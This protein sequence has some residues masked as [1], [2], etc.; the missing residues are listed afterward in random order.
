MGQRSWVRGQEFL[1]LCRGPELGSITH[2]GQLLMPVTPAP[3]DPPSLSGLQGQ[4][5]KHKII[6]NK[7]TNPSGRKTFPHFWEKVSTPSL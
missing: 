1:L 7:Q 5:L 2:T 6:E 3:G 4:L